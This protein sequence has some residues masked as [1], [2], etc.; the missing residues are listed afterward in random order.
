MATQA[1]LTRRRAGAGGGAPLS[2]PGLAG[3]PSGPRESLPSSRA[4]T[5]EA[6]G[7]R[8]HK[9]AFDERDVESSEDRIMPKL[10]L[11]EEVLLL[12]LKDKQASYFHFLF[13]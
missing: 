7:G 8:G 5:P 9:V 11:M 1:G 3:T 4:N 13:V 6:G 2:S 10:T 12:G